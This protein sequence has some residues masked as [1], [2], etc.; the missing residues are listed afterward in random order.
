MPSASGKRPSFL[1]ARASMNSHILRSLGVRLLI[2]GCVRISV[3]ILNHFM[4][5][6][7]M[8]S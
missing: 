6:I 8:A 1:A 7:S 4:D 3:S 5:Q 2:L